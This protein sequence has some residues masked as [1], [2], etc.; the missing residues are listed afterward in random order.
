MV[1]SI[2]LGATFIVGLVTVANAGIA[3]APIGKTDSL[4]TRVAEGC[5][6]GWWR[7]PGGRC[8]PMFNGRACPPGYHLG[9]ERRR[10][11]PNY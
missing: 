3:V 7:G 10:C 11:W 8:H 6:P 1:R 9:P 2:V 4:I 5:G